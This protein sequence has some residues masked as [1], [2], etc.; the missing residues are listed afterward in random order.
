MRQWRRDAAGLA[1]DEKGVRILF[2]GAIYAGM[3]RC[4]DHALKTALTSRAAG[5]CS[6]HGNGNHS[7]TEGKL[8]QISDNCNRFKIMMWYNVMES[9]NVDNNHALWFMKLAFHY[10]CRGFRD[11][12]GPIFTHNFVITRHGLWVLAR[13][14]TLKV[15]AV[16]N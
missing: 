16:S 15:L 12:S 8:R 14:R 10:S 11:F 5:H 13:L 4:V 3:R 7:L 1:G 6:R 9:N 2:L